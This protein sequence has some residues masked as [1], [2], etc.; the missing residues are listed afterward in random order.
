MLEIILAVGLV[1]TF[2]SDSVQEFRKYSNSNPVYEWAL[3]SPCPTGKRPSGF[4]L[5]PTG[6]VVIK[7]VNRDG[8]MGDV[9]LPE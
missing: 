6:I 2:S 8:T 9:C 3:V 7:Q 5:A 4:A 1:S